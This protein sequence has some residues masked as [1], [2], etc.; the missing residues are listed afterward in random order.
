MANFGEIL[1]NISVP[2]GQAV[3][4]NAGNTAFEAY[5]PAS[6]G[7]FVGCLATRTTNQNIGTTYTAMTF[8]S[9]VWD[10]DTMH[11]TSL[12]TEKIEI[13]TAG[14]YAIFGAVEIPEID[15]VPVYIRMLKNG[16]SVL[17]ITQFQRA[18]LASNIQ[19]GVPAYAFADL[20]DT[21]YVTMEIKSI[22]GTTN[23][24]GFLSV[25]KI[26]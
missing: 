6:G 1:S 24:Q 12:D 16:S 4:R 8:P 13:N 2:A 17:G 19:G 25:Y 23:Y 18:N 11:S 10:T 14:K 5:T 22:A 26:G 9:E 20:V 7:S 21:D 15:N 3:R